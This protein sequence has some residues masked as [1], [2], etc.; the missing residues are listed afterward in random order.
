[1]RFAEFEIEEDNSSA[2]RDEIVDMLS[3][4]DGAKKAIILSEIL[5]RKY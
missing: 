4:Q 5:N 2:F 3:T 1:M